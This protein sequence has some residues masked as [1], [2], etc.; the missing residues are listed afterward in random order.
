MSASTVDWRT[1]QRYSEGPLPWLDDVD[2][3][4]RPEF[5][6]WDSFALHDEASLAEYALV[7]W[8]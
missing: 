3:N 7:A 8:A 4:G 6:L 5:I 2:D 1:L